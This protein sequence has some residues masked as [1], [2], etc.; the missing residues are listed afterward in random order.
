MRSLVDR[1]V[2]ITGGAAGIGFALAQECL[3]RG[4]RVSLVDVSDGAA[5]AARLREEFG[6]AVRAA[7]FTADVSDYGQAGPVAAG[8]P[9][10]ARICRTWLHARASTL[11][12]T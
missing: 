7:S 9:G 5:A 4:A 8:W 11:G 6:G 12:P 2:L 3:R 1:N 10:C